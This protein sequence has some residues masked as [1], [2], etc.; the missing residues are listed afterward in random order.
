LSGNNNAGIKNLEKAG[1][2]MRARK[3]P[4]TT[5]LVIAPQDGR[6]RALEISGANAGQF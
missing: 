2:L 3:S 1:V 5:S 6:T 4:Q